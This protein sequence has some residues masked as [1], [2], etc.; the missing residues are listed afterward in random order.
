MWFDL[1]F[2]RIAAALLVSPYR[3]LEARRSAKKT[4]AASPCPA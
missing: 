1:L 3:K 4:E 2:E